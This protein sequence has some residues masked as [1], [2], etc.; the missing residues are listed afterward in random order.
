MF[1]MINHV[2]F[3]ITTDYKHIY[4]YLNKFFCV[5]KITNLPMVQNFRD[6]TLQVSLDEIM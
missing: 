2:K 5:L 6:Y 1:L 4:K 3:Y